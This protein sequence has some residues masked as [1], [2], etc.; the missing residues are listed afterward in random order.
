[1]H[2]VP[3]M[4]DQRWFFG[5]ACRNIRDQ[6]LT[7]GRWLKAQN[8]HRVLVG[9]AGAILY[10]SDAAGLD[11][12][13]LGGYHELPF[14]RAGVQGLP[15]TLELI[16]RMPQAERPDVLA[17]FPTWWGVLPTWFS[18]GVMERFPVEGNVICGGY[19]HVA[20]RADWHTLGV[21]ERIR[22]LPDTDVQVID[23]VDVADLVSEKA[24]GYQFPRPAG[25]WTD[26]H[27][28]P[29]PSDARVD[30]FDAGRRLAGGRSETFTMRNLVPGKPAH[31]VFRTA[32]E[33]KSKI[34]V[35]LAGHVVGTLSFQHEEGW[36][37]VPLAIDPSLVTSGDLAF[38]VKNE[39]PEDFVDY[40]VWLTE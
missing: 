24:H 26:M 36:R 11:I 16:E 27:I 6:H 17:I 40:H 8:P 21:G 23:M 29:D 31:L 32:P 15:A 9:D 30:M 25:G 34:T 4:R 1:M 18:S 2:Q 20:Y 13:G 22:A 33:G 38:E 5:R 37:E 7:M 3:K 12:I 28:L 19:E 39:G 14:A 10:A 35:L